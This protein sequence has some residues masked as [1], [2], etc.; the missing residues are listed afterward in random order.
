MTAVTT[1]TL[2]RPTGQAELDLVAASGWRAWPPRRP[3]QP[4]FYP[5]L[6]RWYAT[7][8]TRE[9]NVPAEGVGYV[10]RFE[11]SASYLDR[12]EV[13]QAGG[14]DVLEY[15][16]PAEDLAEFNTHIVG[17]IQREAEYRGPVGD[18]EFDEAERELGR[19]LPAAWRAYL[20]GRSWFRR[21]SLADSGAYVWLDTPAEAL[22][23][24]ELWL[25]ESDGHPGLAVIGGDGARERLV[26]DL[27]QDPPPV[28]LADNSSDGWPS[29]IH[30][31]DD[32]TQLIER[33]E[34]GTFEF[35]FD[36]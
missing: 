16:I 34:A 28:R 27:R 7:K 18:H 35:T 24:Q 25:A 33:I 21:G 6:N 14:R 10:T 19:P 17:A 23:E 31:A 15:W 36:D 29:T 3:D 5:V 8:I 13:H 11:V 12:Y 32:V 30:Q 1:V 9:W 4:I 20:Q 2:W 26:L 22:E